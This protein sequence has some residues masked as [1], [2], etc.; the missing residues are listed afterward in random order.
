MAAV[1]L[2]DLKRRIKSVISTQK[3]TKAMGLVSTVKFKTSRANLEKYKPYY[4]QYKKSMSKIVSLPGISD[5]VYSANNNA[6]KDMYI[7][8]TSDSGLCGSYNTNIINTVINET[9]GRE[10][11]VILITVG[12]KG[13]NFFRSKGYEIAGEY[14]GLSVN[15]AFK[16]ISSI[17]K[18]GIDYFIAGRVKNVYVVYTQFFSQAKHAVEILKILPLEWNNEKSENYILY[19]PSYSYVYDFAVPR[20]LNAIM[21]N[22]VVSSMTSEFAVRMSS[23]DSAT[24]N[25]SEILAQ[26]KITYNKVRQGNIT[27]EITEIVSGAEALKD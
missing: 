23:M 4:E 3:I 27:R 17:M 25:A 12:Q 18:H 26:L 14:A 11:E 19:E 9:R 7:V 15:P 1:G 5:L 21:Y 8:I 13:K 2:L 10:N 24:K 22:A 6:K 20:Y 16:E